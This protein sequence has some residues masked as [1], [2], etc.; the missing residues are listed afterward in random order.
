MSDRSR[1]H[2][3]A[4]SNPDGRFEP[5]RRE[6]FDDGWWQDDDL[7]TLKTTLGIDRARS[8]ITRNQSPDIPFDRSINP[9]RGCE[10]GCVYCYAPPQPCLS[11]LVIRARFRNQTVRQTRRQ[12]PARYGIAPARLPLS[13]HRHRTNT[14]AYQPIERTQ[15]IMRDILE[16]LLAF[17]IRSPSPPNPR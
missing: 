17:G 10:H 1:D 7:P 14:D 11:R 6:A 2:R 13:G 3:G 12:G 16:V 4:P 15:R 5:H 9:Y 8:V